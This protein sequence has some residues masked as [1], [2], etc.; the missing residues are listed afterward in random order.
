[1]DASNNL[2]PVQTAFTDASGA[3]AAKV[4]DPSGAEWLAYQAVK[5]V[6]DSIKVVVDSLET[7]KNAAAAAGPLR[8]CAIVT[9]CAALGIC[10][11]LPLAL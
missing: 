11:R 6:S 7:A 1:V 3:Y 10:I 8:P 5:V 2:A 9:P 4:A